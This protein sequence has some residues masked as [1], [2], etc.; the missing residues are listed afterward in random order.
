MTWSFQVICLNALL[1]SC[2]FLS[3]SFHFF[4]CSSS[5]P[6]SLAAGRI[7]SICAITSSA[8]SLVWV[9]ANFHPFFKTLIWSWLSALLEIFFTHLSVKSFVAV[10]SGLPSWLTCLFWRTL[11]LSFL[12]EISFANFFFCL[13]LHSLVVHWCLLWQIWSAS[14]GLPIQGSLLTP[15]PKV[16][17]LLLTSGTCASLIQSTVLTFSFQLDVTL[18]PSVDVQMEVVFADTWAGHLLVCIFCWTH[19]A[20]PVLLGQ[21]KSSPI[22][23]LAAELL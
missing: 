6:Y 8:V 13:S 2:L 9:C 20:G 23:L 7:A 16:F 19:C 18:F 12:P 14:Y 22:F 15:L 21:Y 1:C 17:F 4:F 5:S 10:S 3:S 11:C